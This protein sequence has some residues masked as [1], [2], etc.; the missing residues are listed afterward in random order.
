MLEDKEVVISNLKEFH[1]TDDEIMILEDPTY[2]DLNILVREIALKAARVQAADKR[3]L[4]FWY[5]AGHGVQDNM[6]SVVLN[7]RQKNHLYPLEN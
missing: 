2:N 4:T 5:Y 3:I 7:S 6:V 1:F